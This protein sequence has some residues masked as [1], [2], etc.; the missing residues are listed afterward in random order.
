MGPGRGARGNLG[1]ESDDRL[2]IQTT[3]SLQTPLVAGG[4]GG[5]IDGSKVQHERGLILLRL[6][7]IAIEGLQ[8]ALLPNTLVI[9]LHIFP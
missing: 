1:Q 4:N 8:H 9:L 2:C 7:W 3:G 6:G 5:L